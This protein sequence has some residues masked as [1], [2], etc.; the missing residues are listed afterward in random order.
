[1]IT[2]CPLGSRLVV[3][4][5]R[6][7]SVYCECDIHTFC[8]LSDTLA[9]LGRMKLSSFPLAC[10]IPTSL[11]TAARSCTTMPPRIG[12]SYLEFVGALSSKLVTHALQY[13]GPTRH[14]SLIFLT[15]RTSQ[16]DVLQ[17]PGILIAFAEHLKAIQNSVLAE[18]NFVEH[19]SHTMDLTKLD[20]KIGL[21]Q[22]ALALAACAVSDSY[23][24][25]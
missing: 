3:S 21:P 11:R 22:G 8:L 14:R 15:R 23:N 2:L 7:C 12:Y 18:S 1:M 9:S 24:Y 6:K 17:A 13:S 4:M 5:T 10:F 25:L 20:L 19:I 16:R